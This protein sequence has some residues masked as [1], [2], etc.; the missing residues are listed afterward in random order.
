[1]TDYTVHPINGG[2]T[3]PRTWQGT[4]NITPVTGDGYQLIRVAGAVAAD[5]PWLVTGDDA[6]ASA[7][8]SSPP[9]RRA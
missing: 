2:W 8:R 4:F 6:G 5:D 3:D 1:M 9:A 7:S